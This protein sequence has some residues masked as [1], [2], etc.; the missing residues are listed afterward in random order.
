METKKCR[1]RIAKGA[2]KEFQKGVKQKN[3]GLFMGRQN[4]SK[5]QKWGNI[6]SAILTM[7]ELNGEN[8]FYGVSGWYNFRIKTN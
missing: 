1:K 3:T 2:E 4:F 8:L 7:G 5:T 6:K